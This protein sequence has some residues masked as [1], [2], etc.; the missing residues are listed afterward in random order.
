MTNPTQAS[1]AELTFNGMRLGTGEA[2]RRRLRSVL[3]GETWWIPG[4]HRLPSD[5]LLHVWQWHRDGE[6]EQARALSLALGGL[7][8]DD[9]PV[10]VSGALRLFLG[11]PK[12]DDG[13]ALGRA[14]IEEPPRWIGLEDPLDGAVGDLRSALACATAAHAGRVW[15]P[16]VLEA[17]RLEAVRPG[18]G[19][20]LVSRMA[21]YDAAWL[22]AS[23]GDIVGSTPAALRV[24]VL[25]LALRGQGPRGVVRA[26]AARLGEE[27][28]R[29]V[30][31]EALAKRPA[32]VDRFL[33]D[34]DPPP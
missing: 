16:K 29:Q 24:F 8:N 15:G 5:A 9:D 26:A 20:G 30:V 22:L 23:A 3:L 11:A 32:L 4:E 2:L 7:L 13:G 31:A 18:W 17:L 6:V 33:A 28:V 19:A 21:D 10:V 1:Q 12:A 34:L 14:L 27:T 25:H